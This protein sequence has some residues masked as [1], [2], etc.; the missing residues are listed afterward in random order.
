M[1]IYTENHSS[2][3][4]TNDQRHRSG[5]RHE[6]TADE[7][8]TGKQWQE[9][10]KILR[11]RLVSWEGA[12]GGIC[13]KGREETGRLGRQTAR[14]P[15]TLPSLVCPVLWPEHP[16]PGG[17]HLTR[18]RNGVRKVMALLSTNTGEVMGPGK[19]RS[20]SPVSLN[21]SKRNVLCYI[22]KFYFPNQSILHLA[23]AYKLTRHY[24]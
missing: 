9:I 3:S 11:E 6:K 8:H 23:S 4:L 5:Q 24:W 20:I 16:D 1:Q 14:V 10:Q 19:L 2:L 15:G 7:T 21:L 22:R 12:E 18:V 13:L 17:C